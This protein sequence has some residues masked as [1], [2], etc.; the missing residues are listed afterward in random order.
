VLREQSQ[1]ELI[2]LRKDKYLAGKPDSEKAGHH[3]YA[4]IGWQE[5]SAQNNFRRIIAARIP[6]GHFCNHKIN[7]I[8]ACSSKLHLNFLLALLNSKLS[9]WFFRLSST[10]AAV[11]HYQVYRLPTPLIQSDA[12]KSA[13]GADFADLGVAVGFLNS[14]HEQPGTLP[15]EVAAAIGGLCARIQAVE[16]TRPMANRSERSSLS[17]E[18]QHLQDLIDAVLFRCFGLTEDDA[19]YINERL[20]E[21]L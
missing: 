17:A 7:Y 14:A 19:T 1:G 2:Y 11:S 13:D 8:P 16:S 21:M 18:S 4:R 6:K 15:P 20:K 10:N 3:R 9:D 12:T 5:S